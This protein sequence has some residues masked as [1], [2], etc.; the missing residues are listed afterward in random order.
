M[1]TTNQRSLDN[2]NMPLMTTAG[3]CATEAN[4]GK[5][6]VASAYGGKM[7]NFA[8]YWLLKQRLYSDWI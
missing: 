5:K 4:G 6:L 3:K 7:R 8:L 2:T 1:Q